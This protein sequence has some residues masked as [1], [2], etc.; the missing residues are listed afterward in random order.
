MWNVRVVIVLSVKLERS[1][2]RSLVPEAG[3]EFLRTVE[4]V[5]LPQPQVGMVGG[6][7][8]WV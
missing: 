4:A 5:A 2:N 8:G 6:K 7:M 1:S 3:V